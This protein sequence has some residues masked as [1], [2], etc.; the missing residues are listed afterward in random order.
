MMKSVRLLK[1]RLEEA[2]VLFTDSIHN[3]LWLLP[4]GSMLDGEFDGGMRGQDHRIIES[5]IEKYDRYDGDLFWNEI[6][7]N[8]R[9]VRLCPESNVAL[10]KQRQKLT[11]VQKTIL[12][13][14]S[15]EIECY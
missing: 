4:D 10:I 13:N 7:K 12:S 9:C 6:H 2:E 3:A 5:G 14:T 1:K 15:Y 11:D 8:Y